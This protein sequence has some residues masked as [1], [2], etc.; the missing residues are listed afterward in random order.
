MVYFKDLGHVIVGA[1][2]S[3]ICGAGGQAG[4][5]PKAWESCLVFAAKGCVEA[6]SFFLRGPVSF[7]VGLQPTEHGPSMLQKATLFL[8]PHVY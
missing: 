6:E 8:K 7:L 2:N 4:G 5:L 1:G 3:E